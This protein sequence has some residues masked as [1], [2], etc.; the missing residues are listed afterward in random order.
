[1]ATDMSPPRAVS[2][3][4]ALSRPSPSGGDALWR[5]IAVVESEEGESTRR[6]SFPWK[7]NGTAKFFFFLTH[8][9]ARLR[10]P[11]F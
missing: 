10:E 7:Y 4:S 8:V 11:G 9:L 2:A 5:G 6:D 1:M 3:G